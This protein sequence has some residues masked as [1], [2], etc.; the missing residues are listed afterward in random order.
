MNLWLAV[1][2]YRGELSI[3]HN[4]LVLAS[5]KPKRQEYL[6]LDP[7]KKN[8]NLCVQ[9]S[10]TSF[11]APHCQDPASNQHGRRMQHWVS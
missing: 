8:Q 4:L 3:N 5:S 6:G 11:M 2:S 9:R 10:Q 1:A 7:V